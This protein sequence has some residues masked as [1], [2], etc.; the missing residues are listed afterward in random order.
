[1]EFCQIITSIWV[2]C[3]R[4]ASK[5][6]AEVKTIV[7][8]MKKIFPGWLQLREDGF[9]KRTQRDGLINAS[10]LQHKLFNSLPQTH[11]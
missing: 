3:H 6:S 7:A 4:F 5:Q 10:A 11:T 8:N 1:M 2:S 9:N